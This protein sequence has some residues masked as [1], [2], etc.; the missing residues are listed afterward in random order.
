LK[1]NQSQIAVGEFQL[2]FLSDWFLFHFLLN[3]QIISD[4]IRA[5]CFNRNSRGKDA[6]DVKY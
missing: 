1:E 5:V 2:V 6:D 3:I 4:F